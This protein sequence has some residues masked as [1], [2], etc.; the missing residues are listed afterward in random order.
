MFLKIK[1]K[2]IKVMLSGEN[3]ENNWRLKVEKWLFIT[4]SIRVSH[5]LLPLSYHCLMTQCSSF[6]QCSLTIYV[7]ISYALVRQ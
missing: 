4:D 7:K 5:L 6:S 3:M 2:Q 1:Q